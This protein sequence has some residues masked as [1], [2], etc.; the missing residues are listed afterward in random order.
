MELALSIHG[1]E[2]NRDDLIP[3]KLKN[4]LLTVAVDTF[5]VEGS[6]AEIVPLKPFRA[7]S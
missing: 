3:D 1:Q 2:F 7:L 6:G 4:Y 5:E